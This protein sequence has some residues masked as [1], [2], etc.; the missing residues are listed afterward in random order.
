MSGTARAVVAFPGLP[1]V[2]QRPAAA[3]RAS[4]WASCWAFLSLETDWQQKRRC[5]SLQMLER[6]IHSP[7]FSNV[8]RLHVHSL[9]VPNNVLQLP[10]LPTQSLICRPC[11]LGGTTT[12]SKVDRVC[13]S[14][15]GSAGG[16]V[17]AQPTASDHAAAGSACPIA[18]TS[19]PSKVGWQAGPKPVHVCDVCKG[20]RAL[21]L[22]RVP[23]APG[24]RLRVRHARVHGAAIGGC[25]SGNW[26]GR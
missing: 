15:S 10:H 17:E 1:P 20:V 9:T 18:A 13:S 12:R 8:Y 14:L 7:D 3:V 19:L 5:R 23:A 4:C 22:V 26:A 2:E 21:P 16:F 25:A 24:L 6:L 11:N